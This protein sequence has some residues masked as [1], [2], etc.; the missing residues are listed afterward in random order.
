MPPPGAGPP[1]GPRVPSPPG[2][3][4]PAPG[5]P[6]PGTGS[7]FGAP[8]PPGSRPG[9]GWDGLAL[10][11]ALAGIAAAVALVAL[12]VL[13][14][15]RDLERVPSGGALTVSL[16]DGDRRGLYEE[17]RSRTDPPAG[18]PSV[19]LS[20]CTVTG[21]GGATLADESY[22]GTYTLTL[23]DTD[24]VATSRFTARR[25]GEHRIAC[26]GAASAVGPDQDI[27][28]L[29]RTVVLALVLGLGGPLI[30]L[31]VFLVVLSKRRR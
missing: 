26:T 23:G 30:G 24:Y 19:P 12:T 5:F 6:P 18:D 22:A 2:T 13:D 25:E 10:A 7:P 21:P 20:S 11:I 31:I 15:T 4:P 27:G 8:A 1:P 9:R 28:G 16:D 14:K 3:P 29:F 17:D